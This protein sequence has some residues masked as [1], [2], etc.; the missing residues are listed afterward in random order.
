VTET[1]SPLGKPYEMVSIRP[2]QAPAGAEG[3]EWHRYEIRQGSNT[4]SGCRQ[5]D[6]AAVT[7]A[8]EEIIVKLNDRRVNKRGRAHIVLRGRKPA[9]K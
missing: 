5:G 7:A 4:I 1:A 8:V 9:Q 6:L 2:A 3:A